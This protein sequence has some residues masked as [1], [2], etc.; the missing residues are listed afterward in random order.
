MSVPVEL[1]RVAA[2]TAGRDAGK[3]FIIVGIESENVVFV[4]D[5]VLRKLE[6]PKRKKLKHLALKPQ[7]SK[8]IGDKLREGKKVFDPE[9]KSALLNFENEC[10]AK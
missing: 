9:I 7:V 2:S 3:Y 6:K 5:G 10:Q 8:V 4:A 1:G